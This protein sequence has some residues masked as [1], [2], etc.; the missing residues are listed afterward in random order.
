MPMVTSQNTDLTKSVLGGLQAHYTNFVAAAKAAKLRRAK[1]RETYAELNALT[2]RDLAD[3]GIA[4]S[5][6]KRLALEESMKATGA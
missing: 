4:R 2:D 6:I 1:Y 3:I 5:Y